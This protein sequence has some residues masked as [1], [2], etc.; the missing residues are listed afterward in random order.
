MA[1]KGQV[2]KDL[3]HSQLITDIQGVGGQEGGWG[4]MQQDSCKLA[5]TPALISQDFKRFVLIPGTSP[6]C[7]WH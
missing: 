3:F 4:M 5:Y 6:R 2:P 7:G 1:G